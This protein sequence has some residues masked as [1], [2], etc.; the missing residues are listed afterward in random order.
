MFTKLKVK[1]VKK[2]TIDTVSI[3]FDLPSDLKAQFNYNAGQ[4]ITVKKEIAG[5]DVRR[6][7]SLCSSPNQDDFRIG[8]KLVENGKM[9]T[10]L[11]TD[12]NVGD[13]LELIM[14]DFD[15]TTLDL[16]THVKQLTRERRLQNLQLI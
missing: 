1:E 5:E 11:T 3:S 2:E 9:S 14:E 8:V 13:E 7:Y 15:G 6:S 16:Y 12:V 4:Y 10:Y